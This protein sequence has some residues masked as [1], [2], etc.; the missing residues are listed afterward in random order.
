VPDPASFKPSAVLR[1]F[2]AANGVKVVYRQAGD[3][4]LLVEYGELV[5]DLR[6]R[7]RIQALT[8]YLEANPILGVQELSPGVRSIQIKFDSR[9]IEGLEALLDALQFAESTL[10]P[11]EEME[12]P[13]RV[14]HLPL[15]FNASSTKAAIDKYRQSVRDTA[16]WLPSN[17][18]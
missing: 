5:L 3:K 16:P 2:T 9:R 1:E 11:A 13:S 17:I 14:L 10:P 4:N 7:C 6:L 15:A 18:E 8:A 12:I